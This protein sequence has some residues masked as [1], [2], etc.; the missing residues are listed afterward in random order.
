MK[1]IQ[2]IKHTYSGKKLS[3]CD[4]GWRNW[5][6]QYANFVMEEPETVSKFSPE[7]TYL[8]DIMC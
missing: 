7:N 3:H 1:K 5:S 8:C 2:F 4:Y 6:N